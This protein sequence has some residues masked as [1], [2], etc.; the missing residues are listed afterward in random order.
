M[1]EIA[2]E[3]VVGHKSIFLEIHRSCKP[4]SIPIYISFYLINF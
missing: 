4:Q 2:E 3:I 1:K